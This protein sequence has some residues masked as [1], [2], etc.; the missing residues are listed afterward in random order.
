V[1]ALFYRSLGFLR[2]KLSEDLRDGGKIFV[3]Q[4]PEARSTAHVLPLLNLLRSFGPN[5]LLFVT[6]GGA[7]QAGCVT[8]LAPDLLHGQVAQLAPSYEATRADVAS[9]VQVCANAYRLWRES[10]AERGQA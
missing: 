10:A 1:L 6:E 7:Q 5:T 4:H 3:F 2:R 8:Q 9:W